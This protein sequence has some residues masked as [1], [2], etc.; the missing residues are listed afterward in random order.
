MAK[1]TQK[2][3]G[4]RKSNQIKEPETAYLATDKLVISSTEA[5]DEDNYCYW[6]SLI[7]KQ[8][9]ELHYQMITRIYSKELKESKPYNEQPIIFY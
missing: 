8:R 7:P 3:N 6:A 9:L 4:G 5:Q 1:R 2:P